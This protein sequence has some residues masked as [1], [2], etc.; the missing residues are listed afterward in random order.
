MKSKMCLRK[1][2]HPEAV[3]SH[4]SEARPD[5]S[6]L[7]QRHQRDYRIRWHVK[8][9]REGRGYCNEDRGRDLLPGSVMQ[10][11]DSTTTEQG[12]YVVN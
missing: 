10:H 7:T 1:A 6:S 12:R 8:V 5:S 4:H 9:I 2:L 11:L 3:S